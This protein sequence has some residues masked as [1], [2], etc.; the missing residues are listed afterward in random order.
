MEQYLFEDVILRPLKIKDS[1]GIYDV[2]DAERIYLGRW[3]PF[4]EY[5]TSVE[6]TK[7]FVESVIH[8]SKDAS[9]SIFALCRK[10]K[11]IGLVGFKSTDR[12]NCKTE[13]GYW[14]SEKEQGKGI[15][16]RAVKY[17]CKYAFNHL[18]INRINIKCAVDNTSSSNIPK[19]IGFKFEG[20][21]RAGELFPDGSFKD[22]EIYSLLKNEMNEVVIRQ[23]VVEDYAMVFDLIERAFRSE[24]E[25]DH[26]EQFLVTRLRGTESFIP[27]LSLVAVLGSKI[28][29]HILLT[30]IKIGD[31]TSLALAPVSV[32]PEYQ[33][34]GVG[35]MLIKEAHLKAKELGY[36]S[37][38]LLGHKDYYPRFGYVKAEKFGIKLPFDVPSEFV[39]AIELLPDA[40]EN[41]SGTV[42]YHPTFFE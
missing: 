26:K 24:K 18:G 19:Q 5:T 37:I 20:I 9:E 32:L 36:N 33:R 27:Q 3:L 29:G 39:M 25:S 42:E 31:A 23:E 28:V 6:F 8:S 13:I 35:S 7:G 1:K 41:I 22:L 14:I 16:T 4:V 30:Q 2:I 40:L 11:L 12:Q 38:I 21:E 17:L 34:D 10:G 15:V